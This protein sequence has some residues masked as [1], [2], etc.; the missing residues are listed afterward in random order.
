[1]AALKYSG[2]ERR[3]RSGVYG[4]HPK[5]NVITE[6]VTDISSPKQIHQENNYRGPTCTDEV[7]GQTQKTNNAGVA[8]A[9][10]ISGSGLTNENG[11]SCQTDTPRRLRKCSNDQ[12][13][14][15]KKYAVKLRLETRRPSY[16]KWKSKHIDSAN[17]TLTD[18]KTVVTEDSVTAWT[19]EWKN[20]IDDAMDMLR[21]ELVR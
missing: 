10:T 16:L 6:H 8:S 4:P 1:M 9:T 3:R 13:G 17:R 18:E 19:V 15:L 5:L 2:P 14:L 21:N 12:L 11:D 20:T 7:I